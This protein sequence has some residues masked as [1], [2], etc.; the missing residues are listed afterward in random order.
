MSWRS[1]R[2]VVSWLAQDPRVAVAFAVP[3]TIVLLAAVAAQPFVFVP[4]LVLGAVAFVV[5][6]FYRGKKREAELQARA[7]AEAAEAGVRP[8]G[9]ERERSGRGLE[10]DAKAKPLP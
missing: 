2:M 6:D 10:A 1:P 8:P 4:L 5:M 3:L 7:R 9:G